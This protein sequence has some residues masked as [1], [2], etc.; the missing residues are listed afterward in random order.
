[1]WL[2]AVECAGASLWS[3]SSSVLSLRLPCWSRLCAEPR[4]VFS[5]SAQ[6]LVD[7]FAW[8]LVSQM[9]ARPPDSRPH[10]G[11]LEAAWPWPHCDPGA[12]GPSAVGH[13]GAGRGGDGAP[14]GCGLRCDHVAED[15]AAEDRVTPLLEGE[16]QR[17]RPGQGHRSQVSEELLICQLKMWIWVFPGTGSPPGRYTGTRGVRC[18]GA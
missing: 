12:Q 13:A 9:R 5:R 17:S 18:C 15:G 4:A 6:L 2:V 8:C 3:V 1:M 10:L 14:D 16:S 7:R 11:S